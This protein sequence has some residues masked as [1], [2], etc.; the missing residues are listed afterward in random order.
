MKKLLSILLAAMMLILPACSSAPVEM[1]VDDT[2]AAADTT[3][4]VVEETTE[5]ESTIPAD[6]L[7]D[8]LDFKG[9]TFSVYS[10]VRDFFHGELLIKESNGE[11]LNDARYEAMEKVQS[12]LNIKLNEVTFDDSDAPYA[13]ILSGDNTYQ[14]YN[15]RHVNSFNYA[16][17]GI[18][19]KI[20]DIPVIDLD[21][22]WW[23]A[24]FT[25]YLAIGGVKYFGMGAFNLTTYDS[26]HM[27]LFNKDIYTNQQISKNHLGGKTIYETV[28]DGK[29]TYD[30]FRQVM[31]GVTTDVN[32]DGKYDSSDT[33]AYLALDKFSLPSIIIAG[34]YLM[35]DKDKDGKL[36]N[37]MEGNETYFNAYNK[38]MDML[39]SDN[40][41]FPVLTV[42]TEDQMLRDMFKNGQ[43]LFTDCSGGRIGTYREMEVDF[44]MIPY[45]KA[46]ED[47][48]H[49]LSRSE[50]PELFVIP[51]AN[52]ELEYTGTVLE[53]MASEY[54]RSVVPVYYEQSL[55]GRAA[56]DA[57]SA[58]MLDIIY[59]HRV[60]DFGD[61]ILCSEIRDG[62]LRRY[63]A[64]NNRDLASMLATIGSRVQN[65]LDTLNNGFMK[66]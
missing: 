17:E 10:R 6:K 60:F 33:W 49:Y 19:Y 42:S 53:A 28:L 31:T 57:E 9:K 45:P 26:I 63:V 58:D 62:Q 44:G 35:I 2:T 23:D 12:R 30:L 29:W 1:P 46:D 3:A 16:S 34:G 20:T 43:G 65:K 54:Y 18:V 50:Y 25:D 24:E 40:N 52:T 13:L 36:I 66:K 61:T 51:L 48:Q 4:S 11:S 15:T 64:A 21:A 47:Q 7:G 59:G 37:N 39:W 38:I 27:L 8:N 41:W 5:A 55:K 56:R 22:P 14:M 32:G